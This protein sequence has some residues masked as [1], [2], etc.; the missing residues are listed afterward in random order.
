[1]DFSNV[2]YVPKRDN[3]ETP[4]IN[5]GASKAEYDKWILHVCGVCCLKMVG[6]TL[7]KTQQM[8]LYNLTTLCLNEGAFRIREDGEIEGIFHHPLCSVANGLGIAAEVCGRLT[9]DR[10]ERTV[11][12]GRTAMLSVN[13]AK[14]NPDLRGGHLVI[15]HDYDASRDSFLLHDCSSVIRPNGCNINIS[16]QELRSISNHKGLILG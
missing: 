10:L 9:E 11:A 4:W 2:C 8:S 1:M 13:L 7:L 16:R 6:D 14:V 15:V 12:L 3:S 5:F